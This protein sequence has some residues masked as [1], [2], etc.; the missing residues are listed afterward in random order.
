MRN[1]VVARVMA[2]VLTG[3]MVMTTP[4]IALAEQAYH[5]TTVDATVPAVAGLRIVKQNG[6][7]YLC[8]DNVLV[9]SSDSVTGVRKYQMM[10]VEYSESAQFPDD[11]TTDYW[12]SDEDRVGLY[13]LTPGKT[14][15][16][17]AFIRETEEGYNS[18]EDDDWSNY[19]YGAYSPV[20]TYVAQVP[21]VYI[22]ESAV[23]SN[24]VSFVFGYGSGYEENETYYDKTRSVVYNYDENDDG[25]VNADDK[26]EHSYVYEA[27]Y[28]SSPYEEVTGFEIYRAS[29]SGKYKKI[30]TV[31]D[32][33]YTDKNLQSGKNYR[34]KIRAY[35]QDAKTGQ[36]AYGDYVYVRKTTWGRDLEVKA[37]A[38]GSKTVKLTWKRVKGADGYKIYRYVGSSDN[39]TWKNGKRTGFSSSKL[40]KTIK[41]AKTTSFKDKKLQPNETYSYTVVAYKNVKNGKVN[42]PLNIEGYASITLG[43]DQAF[44]VSSVKDVNGNRALTWKKVT[45]AEGYRVE[46]KDSKTGKW[47]AVTTL[48]ANATSYTCTV[49][50]EE[51]S[52]EY[53]LYAFAE[54]RISNY[55]RVSVEFVNTVGRTSGIAAK[56]TADLTGIEVSWA[57]V[58]GAAYYKVYRSR[59]L[60]TANADRSYYNIPGGE[61][62]KIMSKDG[63]V[64]TGATYYESGKYP[65][66]TDKIAG[67]TSIVDKYQGYEYR[68]TK[69]NETTQKY[70]EVIETEEIQ[71]APVAGVQYYY[72]V[73]AFGVDGTPVVENYLNSTETTTLYRGGL[74]GAPAKVAIDNVTLKKPAIKAVKAGKKKA[75][76]SWKKVTGASKYYVYYSTKKNKDYIFAGVT[77]KTKLTVTG[78]E[79][80][81]K[82]YFKIKACAPNAVGADVYSA[83]SSAKSKKV[84]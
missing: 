72:Y 71:K 40:I 32:T 70:D 12:I 30:A 76:V 43:F 51:K 59:Q 74:S 49:T 48:D 7:S 25:Q 79:S 2:A 37:T 69:W 11:E 80:G 10:Y 3:A 50:A 47:Q 16:L 1:K 45:G 82:Y 62:V 41:K 33:S 44:S 13:N 4:S 14:Y 46:K 38:A 63:K 6:T 53:R 29:A 18:E 28:E 57:P 19:K 56:A 77:P 61:I 36:K 58:Q 17:R 75:T 24:S 15:Y 26:Y 54:D 60:G 27:S 8:W 73:Q 42:K 21:E 81:K 5:G 39:G 64:V 68:A 34:Y 35:V 31:A 20:I 66:Y 9:D 52:A 78:L 67:M 83:L 84:R 65:E 55:E 22:A 23:T